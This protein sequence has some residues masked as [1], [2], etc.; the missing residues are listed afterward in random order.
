MPSVNGPRDPFDLPGVPDLPRVP[1]AAD[2]AKNRGHGHNLENP[3]GIP[4]CDPVALPH[5]SQDRLP[6]AQ[7]VLPKLDPQPSFPISSS[8]LR[9]LIWIAAV[10]LAGI[11]RAL[12]KE[13]S[14]NT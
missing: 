1:T 4:S 10:A 3:G 14:N 11:F 12:F 13:Q 2:I 6:N 9:H 8:S 5:M 7:M